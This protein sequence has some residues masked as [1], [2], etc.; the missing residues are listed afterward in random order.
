MHG[1]NFEE[2]PPDIIDG[3]EE[4]EVEEIRGERRVGRA[5]KLQYLVHWKGYSD[6][7]DS[8]EL[9]TDVHAPDLVREYKDRKTGVQINT[10]DMDPFGYGPRHPPQ[11]YRVQ[12]WELS[13]TTTDFIERQ[14]EAWSWVAND[15]DARA[16][17][18]R[19]RDD[20]FGYATYRE[21]DGRWRRHSRAR[22]NRR[23][24][25]QRDKV[26]ELV[27]ERIRVHGL[28]PD[29][30]PPPI[31]YP[32]VTPSP[33]IPPISAVPQ[34]TNTETTTGSSL[35]V[36]TY[37]TPTTTGEASSNPEFR[38]AFTPGPEHP[39][40]GWRVARRNEPYAFDI[41]C[42]N[43][44]RRQ[45]PYIRFVINQREQP[46]IL[47]TEGRDKP[48]YFKPLFTL[49]MPP[50]IEA[51]TPEGHSLALFSE[52]HPARHE[53][54]R[55]LALVADPGAAG[56]VHQFRLSMKRK[57]DLF[58][59]M[60]DLNIVWNDWLAEA[61]SVDSRLRAS[62]ITSRIYPFLPQ[63]LPRGLDITW[64]ASH[65][66]QCR[67]DHAN[68]RSRKIRASSDQGYTMKNHGR[69]SVSTAARDIPHDS[70]L[71]PMSYA[72]N[73]RFVATSPSTTRDSERRVQRGPFI[74]RDRS[75]TIVLTQ[76][77]SDASKK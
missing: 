11:H 54:N 43:G 66:Y 20:S 51:G 25:L 24:R 16:D 47:G 46:V 12:H 7:H 10:I 36:S 50:R 64:R 63:P 18:P 35:S 1:E 29:D 5:K 72:A 77:E 38:P 23:E 17:T 40:V 41:P 48:Q 65:P 61:E 58:A 53:V 27:A 22:A 28:Y 44:T 37:V 13:L 62:N 42:E 71:V 6:A 67:R 33:I 45:I 76:T 49:P 52:G 15:H 59:R 55:A 57:Q 26:E 8:W 14:V 70:A 34:T 4:W 21:P 19:T 69:L 30:V 56:D 74:P 31:V 9:A 3:E 2:P 32:E 73:I 39:G 60:R 75:L 68:P